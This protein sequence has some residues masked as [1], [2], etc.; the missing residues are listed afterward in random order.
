[1]KLIFLDTL[2]QKCSQ[3][4]FNEWIIDTQL[5]SAIDIICKSNHFYI[6]SFKL[7]VSVQTLFDTPTYF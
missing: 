1:M 2:K 7:L 4:Q 3:F 6:L 5:I